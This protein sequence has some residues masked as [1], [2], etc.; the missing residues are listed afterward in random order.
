MMLKTIGN[1]NLIGNPS[2]HGIPRSANGLNCFPVWDFIH[3]DEIV[4]PLGVKLN[5]PHT[6]G[7]KLRYTN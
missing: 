2:A 6:S 4:K 5:L 3:H 1:R 7:I